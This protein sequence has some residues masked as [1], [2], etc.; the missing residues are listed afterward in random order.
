MQ[1]NWACEICGRVFGRGFSAQRHVRL[2][3]NLYGR[4]I[5]YPSYLYKV[6]TGRLPPPQLKTGQSRRSVFASEKIMDK[7]NDELYKKIDEFQNRFVKDLVDNINSHGNNDSS[8]PMEI[9]A[10]FERLNAIMDAFAKKRE[11]SRSE[12]EKVNDKEEKIIL[13]DIEAEVERYYAIL[14]AFDKKREKSRNKEEKIR[15]KEE[16]RASKEE[17][18][19]SRIMKQ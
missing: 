5:D 15:N 3:H 10:K 2:K 16:K 6:N 4:V 17:K 12:E 7:I 1:M 19:T 18:I 8:N 14:D 13:P 11:K 9:I